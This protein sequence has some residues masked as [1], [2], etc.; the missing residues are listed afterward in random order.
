MVFQEPTYLI[1]VALLNGPAHGYR[2]IEEVDRVSGGAVRLR[3]GTLYGA[4]DRLV[5]EDLVEP[6]REEVVGGRLRRYNRLTP[7]GE[8][9][10]A[11]ETTR[12]RSTAAVAV[13]R[14]RARGGWPVAEGAG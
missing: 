10:V 6:D 3:A 13:E 4:L 7:A 5:A 8:A 12:R 1:L 14:L 2:L 11:E 9:R